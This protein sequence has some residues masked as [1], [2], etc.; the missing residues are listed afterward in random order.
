M[1][2]IL[3]CDLNCF[4]A[5]VEMLYHPEFRKVPMAIGGDREN[6]HGIILAKNVPAKN[7]GIRTAE[8]IAE[9]LKKCPELIIRE[10]D[11]DSYQYFSARLRDLYY[12]YT[13]L[14]EP[15][16]IDECWLDISPSI[17]L[18]GSAQRIVDELLFRVKKEIGLTLSIGVSFNKVYAKLGSDLAREDSSC[19]INSLDDIRHLPV[20]NLLFVGE[21][22]CETLKK[23]NILTI[24]DVADKPA[25][26]LETILGKNGRSLYNSANGIGCDQVA[27]IQEETEEIKSVSCN[28]TSVRD[29]KDLD[30]FKTILTIVAEETADRVRRKNMYFRTVHLYLRYRNL[31][32]VSM[33]TSLKENSDLAK[34]IYDNALKLFLSAHD[35]QIPYRSIGVAVSGLSFHKQ[36]AQLSFFEEST[37]SLKTRKQEDAIRQIRQRFGQQ[38]IC[39][40]RLLNDPELSHYPLQNNDYS[41]GKN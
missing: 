12:Q 25:A 6:R 1:K 26:Y 40:L 18:F 30:D 35:F 24:G 21:H 14:I 38:A 41:G 13:D 22:T 39:S 34:D 4:F 15:F 9:A 36:D 28:M 31:K 17:S 33:Q 11:Y 37:Y 3:H 5:S 32:T 27:G 10:A 29:L 8:T 7:R 23:Y 20:G 2:T 19:Y 16:G